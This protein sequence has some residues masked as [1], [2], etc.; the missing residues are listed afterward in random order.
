MKNN[1]D[2]W[3]SMSALV[4]CLIVLTFFIVQTIHNQR[5]AGYIARVLEEN[6]ERN[7]HTQNTLELYRVYIESLR[8]SLIVR[9]VEVPP[10]PIIKPYKEAIGE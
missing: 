3:L 4:V 10:L 6:R 1:L 2:R 8:Q 5:Q 7:G 9:G